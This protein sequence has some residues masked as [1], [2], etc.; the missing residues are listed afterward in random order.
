MPCHVIA[1]ARHNNN[2]QGIYYANGVALANDETYLV[3]AETD[4]IRLLKYWL[5]GPKVRNEGLG[6][7]S[8]VC[9]QGF[10]RL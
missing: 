4:R 1:C 7:S 8:R 10:R 3:L 6:N 9:W 5:H 2:A